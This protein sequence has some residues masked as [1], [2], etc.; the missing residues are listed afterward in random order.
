MLGGSLQALGFAVSSGHVH[1]L[2]ADQIGVL[3][4]PALVLRVEKFGCREAPLLIATDAQILLLCF[5]LPLSL[6][7]QRTDCQ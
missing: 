3:F 2:L 4:L 7:I 1:F 5:V 6:F